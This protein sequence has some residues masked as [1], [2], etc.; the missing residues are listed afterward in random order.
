MAKLRKDQ[1]EKKNVM[2]SKNKNRETEVSTIHA[3]K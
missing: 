2:G 1:G 3:V